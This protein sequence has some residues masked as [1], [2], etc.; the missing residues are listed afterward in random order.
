M[1]NKFSQQDWETCLKVLNVLKDNPLENPDNQQFKTLI[2]S[3]AK[4]AKKSNKKEAL[5]SKKKS[6]NDLIKETSIVLN[7]QNKTSNFTSSPDVISDF[8]HLEIERRCY[9]CSTMYTKL[10]FFYHKLCPDCANY[11]YQQRNK[12]YD[13]TNYNVIITGGR[14]KIGYA[15]V[16]KFL[17]ANAKVI[18]TTRFPAIALE[19]LRHENDYELWKNNLN[20]YGLDLRNLKC[21]QQFIDHCNRNLNQLDILINN[22]AQTIKYPLPYYQPLISTENHLLSNAISDGFHQNQTPLAIQQNQLLNNFDQQEIQLNRFGQPI[23]FRAKN[24][25]NSTLT[26]VT[27]EELLE[28]NLI[29]H[30]SPYQLISGLTPLMLRSNH[31][32]RF[33]INVTSSEGQFNYPNKNIFHPHTNMTKA[34]LNMLTR[35]SANDLVRDSI[36]MNSVDVGWISTGVAESKREKQFNDLKIPPLDPVDGA[37]RILHPIDEVLNG[38]KSLFGVLL[39][40]YK[41]VNW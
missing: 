15:T 33:I 31:K 11:N 26:D 25:W 39:K 20:V 9:C 5:S 29:N 8:K 38:N 40:D 24:S 37:A 14:V 23:D 4:Q 10:H 28:V 41:V 6:N 22:A 7:A 2:T 1:E 17:R 36:F 30:I 16:L 21:V 32:D 13:L 3:I 34:A 18:L 35:T 19:Q 27:L 12:K